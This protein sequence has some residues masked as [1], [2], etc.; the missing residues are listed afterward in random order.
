MMLGHE[1]VARALPT[2]DCGP[3][4]PLVQA[5]LASDDPIEKSVGDE[6]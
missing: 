1:I 3:S 2:R 5:D 6:G 4:V